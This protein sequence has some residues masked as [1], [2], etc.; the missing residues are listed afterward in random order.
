MG[1]KIKPDKITDKNPP[2][3]TRILDLLE[4]KK[5]IVR[6][7]YEADRKV[8]TVSATQLGAKMHAD[9]GKIITN[10]RKQAWT[11]LNEQDYDDLVRIMDGIY[12]N[13]E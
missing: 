9:A 6:H 8:M 5:L 2:T 13:V 4:R 1:Q 7:H 3:I 12:K 11:N 10:V